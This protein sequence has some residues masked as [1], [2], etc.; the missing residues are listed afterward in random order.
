[1][2]L[3]SRF[4]AL[5]GLCLLM[6]AMSGCASAPTRAEVPQFKFTGEAPIPLRAASVVFEE[7]YRPAGGMQSVEQTHPA[8]PSD[9]AHAW[10]RDRI[11]L[12]GSSGTLVVR[13]ADAHV[14]QKQLAVEKG[15]SGLLKDEADRQLDARLEVHI[16]LSNP[17]PLGYVTA[18]ATGK[19]QLGEHMSMNEA[20]A[21]YYALLRE[22]ANAF[23]TAMSAEVRANLEGK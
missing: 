14:S 3:F 5:T 1:M 7:T 16:A 15:F 23:D 21:A 13:I 19:Q 11:R 20:E 8:T 9:I 2:P 17:T 10:V 4:V 18:T 12:V 6:A 22:M